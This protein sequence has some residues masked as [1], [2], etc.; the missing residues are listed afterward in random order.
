MKSLKITLAV[1]VI[2][3]VFA[4]LTPQDQPTQELEKNNEMIV[5]STLKKE[6]KGIKIPTA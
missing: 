1:A 2:C 3:A 5:K 6:R 4:S